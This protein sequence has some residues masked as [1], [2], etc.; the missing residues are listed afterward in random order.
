MEKNRQPIFSNHIFNRQNI[1][2]KRDKNFG[3]LKERAKA[4]SV[5]SKFKKQ[6]TIFAEMG[7]K[8]C[9]RRSLLRRYYPDLMERVGLITRPSL[10]YS[11]IY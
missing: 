10:A 9:E 11:E 7:V 1:F 5:I 8:L 2:L 3:T 6:G 4:L